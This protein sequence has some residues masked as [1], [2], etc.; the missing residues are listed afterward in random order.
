MPDSRCS[1][2]G[3]ERYEQRRVEYIYTHQGKH[4]LVPNTPVEVC[5]N[6]GMKYYE[7]GV[8]EEIERQFFAI[9]NQTEE[10][11]RYVQVP[12]KAYQQ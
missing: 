11:D 6:C 5:L 4:L 7:A 8:L 10:P 12:E 9:E 3:H 1:F 2:C